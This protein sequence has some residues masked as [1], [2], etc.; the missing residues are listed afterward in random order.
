MLLAIMTIVMEVSAL[1]SDDM[2]RVDAV[3]TETRGDA[4]LLALLGQIVPLFSSYQ[5]ENPRRLVIEFAHTSYAPQNL[6]ALPNVH[7]SL[8]NRL[9]MRNHTQNDVP[10]LRMM[11]YLEQPADFDVQ[12]DEQGVRIL[13]QPFAASPLALAQSLGGGRFPGNTAS[14]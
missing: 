3:H 12:A 9:E 6:D 8:V 4:V 11:F 10:M 13:L 7:T 1:A 2:N 14:R 5:L